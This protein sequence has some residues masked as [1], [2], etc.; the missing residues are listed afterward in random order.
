MFSAKKISAVSSPPCSRTTAPN[1]P[2]PS[3]SKFRQTAQEVRTQ[4]FYTRPYTATDKAHVERNHEYIRRIV[5]KGE[6]FDFSHP[7]SMSI[8]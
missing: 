2:I 8:L 7:R 5:F 3:P 4:V 1:S 6:S